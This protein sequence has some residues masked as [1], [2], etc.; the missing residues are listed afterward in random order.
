[1]CK[2]FRNIKNHL[3]DVR[4]AAVM[5]AAFAV[6]ALSPALS[7]CS[8]LPTEDE[9]LPPPVLNQYER[10]QMVLVSVRRDNLVQTKTISC[11]SRPIREQSYSFPVGGHYIGNVYFSVG[12][13]VKAGDM[14]AELERKDILVQVEEAR[15]NVRK[16]EFALELASDDTALRREKYKIQTLS[17]STGD[18]GEA[19]SEDELEARKKQIEDELEA[20]RKQYDKIAADYEFN[21]SYAKRKLEIAQRLLDNLLEIAEERVIYATIDGVISYAQKFSAEDRS[22]AGDKVFTVSDASELIYIVS[23]DDA[24][25]FTPGETY[26]MKLSKSFIDMLAV[27]PEEFNEPPSKEP[28]IFFKTTDFTAGLASYGYISIETNRRDDALYL[29]AAAIIQVGDGYAVYRVG[30]EGFRELAPIEKGV[31]ISGKTEILGGL[32]EGDEV[33]L[34]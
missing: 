29:P 17:K 15:I 8:I 12:D 5:L 4:I 14:L 25:F 23:G 22:V 20:H 7:A 16:L 32:S 28:V 33:I 18:G 21:V 10:Q 13:T 34:D 1:M 9:P 3:G 19:A 6:A 27:S 26:S 31:T 30:A 2:I 11:R 24:L